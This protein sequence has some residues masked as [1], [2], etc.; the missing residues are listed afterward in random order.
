MNVYVDLTQEFNAGRLRCIISSGQ[1]VVLHHLAIMS[2]DGDWI[3]REDGEALAHVLAV[4]ETHGAKYRFG[5]PL[6]VRWM[7]GGWSAHFE[8]QQDSL[9]VRTDF[10]TRPARIGPD[11]LAR[12]W[13][14]QAEKD[15]PVVDLVPLAE[16]KKT[17]REKDYAIIGELARSMEDP[18][19]QIL[20]SRSARDL[21]ALAAAHPELM[22]GLASRR[23]VL[24]AVADGVAALEAALDAE[25]RALMH[26]NEDRLK[27]YLEAA[28][29]WSERWPSVA[30]AI[31]GL[32]LM[33]AHEVVAARAEGVLPFEVTGVGAP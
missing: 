10:V 30:R 13:Q 26:A 32:P 31:E 17:N 4:L 15:P 11:A 12:L 8:F 2:K 18:A 16:I 9:R 3:A 14:A 27:G 20:Y 25:R 1:A 24:R 29:S 7:R 21:L 5:A 28:R 23:P 22:A 19:D 33:K 6:D